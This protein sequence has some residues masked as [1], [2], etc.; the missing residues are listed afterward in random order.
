MGIT[1]REERDVDDG[2]DNNDDDDDEYR[3]RELSQACACV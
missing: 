2:S 1:R 3:L